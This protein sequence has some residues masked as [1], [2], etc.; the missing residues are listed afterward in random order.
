MMPLGEETST[1]SRNRSGKGWALRLSR[2]PIQ[3][4]GCTTTVSFA[5]TP[6]FD[7]R[8]IFIARTAH[9]EVQTAS[10]V[11]IKARHGR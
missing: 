2:L 6:T 8:G 4:T 9:V 5:V 11:T 3:T 10:V 7:I 1:K